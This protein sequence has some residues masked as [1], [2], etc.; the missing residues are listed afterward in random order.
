MSQRSSY[1]DTADFEVVLAA[2]RASNNKSP[3]DQRQDAQA[4]V[5]VAAQRTA[6]LKDLFGPCEE[7]EQTMCSG[8]V[9]QL[10]SSRPFYLPVTRL[11]LDRP[12]QSRL[13]ARPR[14]GPG[15]G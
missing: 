15:L 10:H 5:T 13:G 12:P 2:Q 4:T 1:H 3:I 14:L 8:G 6:N 7:S 9:V 11:L